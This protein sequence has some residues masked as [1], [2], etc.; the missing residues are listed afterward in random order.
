[1]RH[2]PYQ[3]DRQQFIL[4]M[5]YLAT[6]LLGQQGVRTKPEY[7]QKL[8]I[9]HSCRLAPVVFVLIL[10]YIRL[11]IRTIYLAYA[12]TNPQQSKPRLL[13]MKLFS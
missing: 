9:C 3:L 11:L 6:D 12:L 10:I 8:D 7:C 4:V 1:M 2:D 13:K 5:S